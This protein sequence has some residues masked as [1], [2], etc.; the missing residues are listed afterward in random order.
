MKYCCN[1]D[2]VFY[3]IVMTNTKTK[4]KTMTKTNTK[5]T[6]HPTYAIFLKSWEF[7][8]IR[9]DAYNDK[10][11]EQEKDNDNDNDKD[12]DKDKDK[13]AEN[14]NIC[15]IFKKPRIQGYQI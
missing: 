11:N 5:C 9:Y 1:E 6:E 8:D 2:D 12:K 15:Y 14:L 4:T 13:S 3:H 10:D 7:R